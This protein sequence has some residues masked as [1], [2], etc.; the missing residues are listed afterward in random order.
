MQ[1][2]IPIHI[3]ENNFE[4]EMHLYNH[5]KHFEGKCRKLF[6]LLMAG[7]RLT[8]YSA[9]VEYGIASLPRRFLDITQSGAQ[10]SSEAMTGTRIKEY[11][12]TKEQM[13][14]NKRFNK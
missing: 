10:A 6:N 3:R 4:N 2:E 13:E 8:V 9:L 1:L 11:F 5:K 12:M 7:H 14:Y